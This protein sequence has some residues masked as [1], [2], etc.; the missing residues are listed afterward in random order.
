M[1]KILPILLIMV[2][3]SA[4]VPIGNP[5]LIEQFRITSEE[6]G[7]I[8]HWSMGGYLIR[9]SDALILTRVALGEAPYCLQ[10]QIYI[11]WNIKLRAELGYKNY[12]KGP[13][14]HKIDRWGA[15][16]SIQMEALCVGGCQYDIV[17]VIEN[18][19]Y[20]E[21]ADNI[22]RLMLHPDNEQLEQFYNAY[23]EAVRILSLPLSEMPEELIGYDGFLSNEASDTNFI[24]WY[25]GN[26][27]IQLT[28]CGNVWN[29]KYKED[30]RWFI[31]Q[32]SP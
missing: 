3:L 8:G 1:R 14:A 25:G 15:P 4:A 26:K 17:R 11:M 18:V 19:I 31:L 27:R 13:N 21:R 28:S 12:N 6:V 24:D 32:N 29:D 10:D 9:E 20:P 2:L 16:T 30:N 7:E 22:L 23:E 5:L